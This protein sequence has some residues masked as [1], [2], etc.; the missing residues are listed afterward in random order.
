MQM[1]VTNFNANICNPI[2]MQMYAPHL[3]ELSQW[4]R[5]LKVNAQ[6]QITDFNAQ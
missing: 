2:F 3:Q 1:Y 4:Q 6:L 5:Y